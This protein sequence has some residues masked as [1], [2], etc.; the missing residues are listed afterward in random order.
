[1]PALWA[2]L[3]RFLSNRL[4]LAWQ[5]LHLSLEQISLAREV[6]LTFLLRSAQRQDLTTGRF[7]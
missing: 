7:V 2:N 3:A 4:P 1:M 6:L 5:P